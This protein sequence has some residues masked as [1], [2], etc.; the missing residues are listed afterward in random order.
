MVETPYLHQTIDQYHVKMLTN[1]HTNKYE[2]NYTHST[3]QHIV[4]YHDLK[5]II[6]ERI[7]KAAAECCAPENICFSCGGRGRRRSC[8]VATTTFI[9]RTWFFAFVMLHLCEE[10]IAALHRLWC[11]NLHD[12]FC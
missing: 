3:S 9:C 4:F 8:L 1:N 11:R 10:A 12:V 6:N 2:A 7:A 5:L